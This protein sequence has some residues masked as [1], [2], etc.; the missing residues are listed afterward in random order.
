MLDTEFDFLDVIAAELRK[1]EK[2]DISLLLNMMHEKNRTYVLLA[3]NRMT[4]SRSNLVSYAE[5][6]LNDIWVKE[7]MCRH[8]NNIWSDK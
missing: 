2:I 4:M 7:L 1:G 3:A 6:V 8:Y 5:K